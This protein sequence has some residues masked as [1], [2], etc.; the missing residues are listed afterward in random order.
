MWSAKPGRRRLPQRPAD[1]LNLPGSEVGL[2]GAMI[3]SIDV[4]YRIGTAAATDFATVEVDKIALEAANSGALRNQSCD[5]AGC[6]SDTAAKRK[7]V[8]DHQMTVTITDRVC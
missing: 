6:Q 4:W 8:E 1:P 7:A 3:S 5:H 2:Q